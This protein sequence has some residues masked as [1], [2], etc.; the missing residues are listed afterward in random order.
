[1][2]ASC[3]GTKLEDVSDKSPYMMAIGKSVTTLTPMLA[4][5]VTT[6]PNYRDPMD[7]I[8]LV[9]E[10][11]FGGPEVIERRLVPKGATFGIVA[12]KKTQVLFKER[13]TYIVMPIETI[14]FPD[15]PIHIKLTSSVTDDNFGLSQDAF[16]V[17]EN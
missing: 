7:Y 2:L 5:G 17:K 8:V 11:G 16:R 14:E 13:V 6:N 10:P 12:V 4:I 3:G 9:E 15:V 1:V